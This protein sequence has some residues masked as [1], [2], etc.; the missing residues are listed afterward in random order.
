M[1][2]SPLDDAVA[3]ARRGLDAA[4]VVAPD[5]LFLMAAGAGLL[6]E[7]L[8]SVGELPLERLEGTPELWRGRT[9]YHGTLAGSAGPLS[10]WV[11]AARR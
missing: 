11:R 6:S 1:T 5:A 9:L 8:D 10:A 2:H 4:E 3:A 7:R